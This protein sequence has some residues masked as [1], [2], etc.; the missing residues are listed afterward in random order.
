MKNQDKIIIITLLALLIFTSI[1]SAQPRFTLIYVV[2]NGDTIYDIAKEYNTT[3]EHILEYNHIDNASKI[4][5]GDELVIKKEEE[6]NNDKNLN[7][8]YSLSPHND[9]TE[10]FKLDVGRNYSV[11]YN[12]EQP[13]PDVNIPP[14]KIIQYFVDSGDTLYDLAQSFNTS[15]GVIMALNNME[16]SIIR[17]GQKLKLPILNL[18]KRQVLARTISQS[19]IEIMARTIHGEARG[20][21]YMG[22]VAVGAVI[23]NRILSNEFP[24]TIKGVIYQKNQFTAVSDGQIHYTPNNTAY[25]AAREA[26]NGVDPTLGSLY[27]YNPE[28]AQNKSFFNTRKFVVSIGDHV[29]AK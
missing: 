2:Q 24:D 5:I 7:L 25:R 28:T 8:N 15:V 14:D 1:G 11:R 4:N 23:I 19:D 12:P 21:P 6:D 16:N 27:Y 3:V 17:Q 26:I 10:N 13:L 29:F 9:R 20:E 22:Q 18:S